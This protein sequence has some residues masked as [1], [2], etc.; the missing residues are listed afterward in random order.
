MSDAPLKPP[1]PAVL[2]VD[3][4]AFVVDSMKIM[5]G[6]LGYRSLS[7][8][9]AVKG[10]AFA[11]KHRPQ[12]ILLDLSMPEVDGFAFLLHQRKLPEIQDIPV[13]VL[14]ASHD[15]TDVQ[16]AVQLGAADY[17][18]KPLEVDQ[19]A[20][21]LER[22]APSPLYTPANASVVDWGVKFNKSLL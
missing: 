6:T 5:L 16:R 1:R 21:R 18:V 4:D 11:V 10:L 14:T 7:A 22:F 19:L 12:A 20:R 13:I 8:P 2:I 9:G 3:D 15:K 17:L